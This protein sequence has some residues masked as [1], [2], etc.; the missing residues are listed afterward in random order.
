[1]KQSCI[2]DSTIETEYIAASEVT[3]KDV[4]LDKFPI[5]LEVIS[6]TN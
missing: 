3:K 4:W 1:M 2:I 5:D 6:E